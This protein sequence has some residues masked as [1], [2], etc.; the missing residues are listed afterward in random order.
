MLVAGIIALTAVGGTIVPAGIIGYQTWRFWSAVGHKEIQEFCDEYSDG[1]AEQCLTT[2]RVPVSVPHAKSVSVDQPIA[3]DFSK[4]SVLA[5]VVGRIVR[6]SPEFRGVLHAPSTIDSEVRGMVV[7]HQLRGRA[8][9]VN[10]EQELPEAPGVD[11]ELDRLEQLV[12]SLLDKP[13]EKVIEEVAVITPE[14][15]IKIGDFVLDEEA[16]KI[17]AHRKVASG[18]A[19]KYQRAVIAEVRSR[20]GLVQWNEAN[21]LAVHKFAADIM[22]R[23]GV[24]P[25]H[26]EQLLPMIV[27]MTFVPNEAEVEA[28]VVFNGYQARKR[29]WLQQLGRP[30]MPG[31]TAWWTLTKSWK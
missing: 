31:E 22:R 23:H 16:P 6:A 30:A 4:N 5:D 25:T 2:T 7:E 1:L 26:M 19:S 29:R 14:A 15:P 12:D 28:N 3:H 20:F 24:R 10:Y 9:Q 17:L 27:R 18:M 11:E 21:K 8:Q 13:K